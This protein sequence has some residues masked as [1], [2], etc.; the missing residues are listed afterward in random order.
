MNKRSRTR[1]NPNEEMNSI[2]RSRTRLVVNDEVS[3]T[4]SRTRLTANEEISNTRSRTRSNVNEEI[5]IKKF[6]TRSGASEEMSIPDVPKMKKL[7]RAQKEELL[8]D[9][10]SECL[11]LRGEVSQ[12]RDEMMKSKK[13][14]Q[15]VLKRCKELETQVKRFDEIL[16]RYKFEIQTHGFKNSQP[17]I[18]YRSVGIQVNIVPLLKLKVSICLKN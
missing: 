16:N 17:M 8:I 15:D 13:H 5:S 10:V 3:N 1:S 4:R 9:K 14:H 18:Q 7:T 11:N 2:K 6:R 12:L